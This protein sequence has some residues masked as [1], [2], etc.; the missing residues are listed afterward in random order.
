MYNSNQD[1]DALIYR[2]LQDKFSLV[3]SPPGYVFLNIR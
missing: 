2:N 3:L 1:N